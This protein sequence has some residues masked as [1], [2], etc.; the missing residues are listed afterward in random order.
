MKLE[1]LKQLQQKGKDLKEM[2]DLISDD[3]YNFDEKVMDLP[4]DFYWNLDVALEAIQKA[5]QLG[6]TSMNIS[7]IEEKGFYK[8]I[9]A[10]IA[11][12]R[13]IDEINTLFKDLT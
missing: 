6:A 12:E 4:K 9:G 1:I 2:A 8:R 7:H 5:K 10:E 13:K 3:L 11:L